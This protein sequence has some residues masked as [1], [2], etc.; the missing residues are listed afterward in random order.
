MGTRPRIKILKKGESLSIK[1]YNGQI[2]KL[3]KK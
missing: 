1:L 3:V 2:L